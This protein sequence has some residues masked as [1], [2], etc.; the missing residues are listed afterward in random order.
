MKVLLVSEGEHE[1]SGALEALVR[2]IQPRIQSFTWKCIKESRLRIHRGKGQG[3]F[4][5]AVSWL[6]Q[7]RDEHYDALVLVIDEDGRSERIR[8]INL[9]Q[10]ETSVT[11]NMR[12]ALGVAI[13]TFDAWLLA[14]EKAL[15][16]ILQYPV[17]TQPAPESIVDP[18]TA[19]TELLANSNCGLRQREFYAE[20]AKQMNL[21]RL[22]E[23]C[24]KG[25]G[26]FAA[27]LRTL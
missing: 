8:E 23:R 14:D 27:R 10:D 3:F 19:C 20:V 13:K 2:G 15:A 4:K 21:P 11:G 26:V 22:E 12:R 7:A 24:S 25:F 17:Q 1:A 5:R 6:L 16:S 9:A 18:K